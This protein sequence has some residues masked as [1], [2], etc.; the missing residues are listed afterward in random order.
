MADMK[1]HFPIC[2]IFLI[3]IVAAHAQV[4]SH[5]PTALAQPPAQ[6]QAAQPSAR[7]VARVNGSILTDLDLVREEYAI[8]PY[9]RQH[10][11]MPKEMEPDIRKGAMKM[12]IFEELVYQE[13]LRRKMTVS[14]AKLDRAETAFRKTFPSP[15]EFNAF[16]QSDFHGS[17]AMVREKIKRSLL[18]E[19]LMKIEVEDKAV[20][21]P[22]ELKAYYDNNPARFEHPEQYTFQTISILPPEKA[23]AEQLTEGKKRADDALKQAKTTKTAEEFG[24]LAEKISDDDFRVMMGQH[25]P[26]EVSKLAPVVLDSLKTM[27]P[28]DVSGLIQLDKAYTIV[29][30]NEHKPAGEA[31]LAEVKAQ[32]EK[33]LPQTRREKLRSDLDRKLRQNATIQE[34]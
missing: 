19:A 16:V 22:A 33:E 23:T 9:A 5:A 14:P 2:S 1:S 27:K 10:G 12:M 31:K 26:I 17:I 29:R 18:I 13:A 8:F 4:A 28:G 34:L 7:P 15:D 11:G 6:G 21:S 30:L 32:L 24:L 25:K 20:V 3:S